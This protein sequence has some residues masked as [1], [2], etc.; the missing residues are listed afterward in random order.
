MMLSVDHCMR[1]LDVLR[2]GQHLLPCR[3]ACAPRSDHNKQS[4]CSC[5]NTQHPYA[6]NAFAHRLT[7]ESRSCSGA[8]R[9]NVNVDVNVN[10]LRCVPK[11]TGCTCCALTV[12]LQ[13][14]DVSQQCTTDARSWSPA[15]L[16]NLEQQAGAGSC[17][18]CICVLVGYKL[19]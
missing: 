1:R 12:R 3:F 17:S 7:L 2:N 8:D 9:V 19:N 6:R 4:S 15:R 18:G 5:W 10:V 14:C 11:S 16:K 13:P